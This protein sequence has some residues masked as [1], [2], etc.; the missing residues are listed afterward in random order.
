[1]NT[2]GT[3]RRR[4]ALHQGTE[5]GV[6]ITGMSGHSDD[7]FARAEPGLATCAQSTRNESRSCRRISS[8]R[9]GSEGRGL[10]GDE[11]GGRV[12]GMRAA[13]GARRAVVTPAVARFMGCVQF[14]LQ[15]SYGILGGRRRRSETGDRKMEFEERGRRVGIPEY[16][17]QYDI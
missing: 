6:W 5:A 4:R 7:A 13:R 15:L 11:G 9:G 12:R 17:L 16:T 8:W 2:A 10:A 3:V 14:T 1:M